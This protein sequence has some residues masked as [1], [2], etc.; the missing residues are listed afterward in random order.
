MAKNITQS[1]FEV[2][3]AYRID[4]GIRRFNPDGTLTDYDMQ[5]AELNI[6]LLQTLH[7]TLSNGDIVKIA[8]AELGA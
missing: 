4:K 8:L 1:V 6:R 5:S 2:C 3:E 7:P